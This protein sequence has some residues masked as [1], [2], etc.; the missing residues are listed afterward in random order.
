MK[1]GNMK[2]DGK[3]TAPTRGRSTAREGS[4]T[5]SIPF[6]GIKPGQLRQWH[7]NF[8]PYE[9]LAG[10]AAI[11]DK[12]FEFAIRHK[13]IHGDKTIAI[14]KKWN[15]LNYLL[16]GN[17]LVGFGD[18]ED[19]HVAELYKMLETIVPRIVEAVL[20]PDP[21]FAVKGRTEA[22]KAQEERI[23]AFLEY[24]LHE[25]GFKQMAEPLIRAM[26]IYN[27][28]PVKTF[29]DFETDFR[30]K[31]EVEK[32][33]DPSKGTIY[34]IRR[35]EIEQVVYEG[36]G[37]SAIDPYLWIMDTSNP[38]H[39][40]NMLCGD[41]SD[42]IY[43]DMLALQ[44]QG[45]FINVDELK[46]VQPSA[47]YS[48]S[49]VNAQRRSMLYPMDGDTS[50]LRFPDGSARRFPLTELWGRFDIYGEGRTRECVVTIANDT[51]VLRVQENPFDDKHRPYAVSRVNEDAFEFYAPGI[52]DHAIPLQIELDRHR[53]VGIKGSELA[54]NPIITASDVGDLPES[55]WDVE[56]GTVFE[57][58]KGSIDTIDIKSPVGD[59][60]HMEEILRRDIEEITG[61]PRIFEG[62]SGTENTATGI[63]R[64]I[65]EGNRRL[66]GIIRSFSNLTEQILYQLHS[67]NAQYV[68]TK[69]TFRVL[70]KK[71]RGLRAYE[72][73]GPETFDSKVDFEFIGISNLHTLG[74]ETTNIVN[75]LQTAFPFMQAHPGVVDTPFALDLLAK[76]MFGNGTGRNIV[77]VPDPL[78]ELMHQADELVLMM[79]GEYVPISEMD[80]DMEHLA[81]ID[82]FK[83]GETWGKLGDRVQGLI[84]EHEATH[85]AMMRQKSLREKA[86]QGMSPTIAGGQAGFQGQGSIPNEQQAGTPSQTPP[87]ETPG[88]ANLQRMTNPGRDSQTFQTENGPA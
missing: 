68:T 39:Q 70:G 80:D 59:L 82:E 6:S 42:M 12:A 23:Q 4:S 45:V 22:D 52:L 76:R 26:V 10:N 78:D 28:I 21:F 72:W 37:L 9:N 27:F 15:V 8:A 20:D 64:K 1:T 63:E 75:F 11:R 32:I 73:V 35:R 19:I 56:P 7:E 71:A 60:R 43:D 48:N 41:T 65:E 49:D 62:T 47:S 74:L 14:Q 53:Q 79:S 77:R 81:Y 31:R 18:L 34:K 69:K 24:Q 5:I 30:V 61:A 51:T 38:D 17:S 84:L 54:I 88:P 33:E 40:K 87:G 46:D 44:D 55:I 86:S 16:Q 85:K 2:P 66:R 36:A 13:A 57:V 83:G 3:G 58:P 25:C 50:D 67:M 29:W